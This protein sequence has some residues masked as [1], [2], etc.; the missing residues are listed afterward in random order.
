MGIQV[1]ELTKNLMPWEKEFI[2]FS[3]NGHHISEFGLVATTSSDR[4]SFDGSPEFEDETSTINGVMGQYYWG[5]T[6]KTKKYTYNLAT[7]G[8]TEQ[9]FSEFKRL[10]RPGYYGQ[11]YED[12]WWDRYCYV[13]I[14]SVVNFTFVPFLAEDTIAG[15]PLKTRIYKGECKLTLIQD[16]PF[17]FAFQHVL[18]STIKDLATA[19]T[20]DNQQAALRMM[21]HSNIPARDSWSGIGDCCIGANQLIN[22]KGTFKDI[23]FTQCSSFRYYNP[24]TYNSESVLRFSLRH[25]VNSELL[26][27]LSANCEPIYFNEINDEYNTAAELSGSLFAEPPY[28]VIGTTYSVLASSTGDLANQ[29]LSQTF[30]FSLPE[31]FEQV[32]KAI[33]IAHDYYEQEE[34]TAAVSLEERLREELVNGKVLS[35]AANAIQTIMSYDGKQKSPQLY[36]PE[37]ETVDEN[38]GTNTFTNNKIKIYTGPVGNNAQIEVNWFGF[39][40]IIMLCMF[41]DYNGRES[42]NTNRKSDDFTDE[43]FLTNSFYDYTL[44]FDSELGVCTVDY[45]YNND[46]LGGLQC[47][48]SIKENCSNMALSPYLMLDG[49]DTLDKKT[50]KINSFHYLI[51]KKGNSTFTVETATLKY[52]YTYI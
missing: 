19:K 41:A 31:T 12:T 10:F 46:L 20:N 42:Q 14:E 4:Y 8:M 45:K 9:Q 26:P 1:E 23:I 50:G 27:Q 29:Q 2:D 6:I 44:T 7:D 15:I 16:K 17:Q 5:T 11:F 32:N 22:Q 28:N 48:T 33:K 52:K 37:S 21:Y 30:K 3:F 35:W 39:F 13:R 51:F 47:L 18:D 24:S 25:A 36:I 49:G 40:N 38:E 43:T 34:I